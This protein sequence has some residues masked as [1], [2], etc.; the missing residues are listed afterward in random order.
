M[1]DSA[2][3]TGPRLVKRRRRPPLACEQCRKRKIRCDRNVPCNHCTKSNIESCTYAPAHVP[4]LRRRQRSD[5]S[6]KAVFRTHPPAHIRPSAS[7]SLVDTSDSENLSRSGILQQLAGAAQIKPTTD[8]VSPPSDRE[9]LLERISQ[10][11]RKLAN[12][13][14]GQHDPHAGDSALLNSS[15]QL[16]AAK[17]SISKTRYFGQSHWMNG[18]SLVSHNC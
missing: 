4:K 12:V 11:E 3:S 18:A 10:L 15:P 14:H 5:L 16:P 8:L 7:G 17:G 9:S 2:I 1:S 13:H 6:D